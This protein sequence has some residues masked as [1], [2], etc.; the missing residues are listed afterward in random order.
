MGSFFDG[1]NNG[2]L[3]NGVAEWLDALENKVDRLAGMVIRLEARAEAEKRAEAWLEDR[4][5]QVEARERTDAQARV[6]AE[7]QTMVDGEAEVWLRDKEA[8]RVS[9]ISTP[10]VR[11]TQIEAPEMT[12]AAENTRE[13]TGA[14]ENTQESTGSSGNAPENTRAWGGD[15]RVDRES[16]EGKFRIADNALI[17]R[18]DRLICS[19]QLMFQV[20]RERNPVAS[21]D[22]MRRIFDDVGY[23]RRDWL[24]WTERRNELDRPD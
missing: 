7:A 12:R 20:L 14:A 6:Q 22:R 21:I 24:E 13:R 15:G 5:V 23:M 17:D 16:P 1:M 2:P 11:N 9:I 3:P 8:A 4:L 18:L 19:S 10:P